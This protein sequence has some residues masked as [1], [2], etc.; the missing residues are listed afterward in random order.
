MPEDF[1]E[2]CTH[3]PKSAPLY[4]DD[5]LSDEEGPGEQVS[6]KGSVSE[7]EVIAP[8]GKL[9]RTKA[10]LDAALRVWELKNL[11]RRL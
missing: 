6:E 10:L 9:M 1:A 2:E 11:P 8:R 5:A 7:G 3:Y 4:F